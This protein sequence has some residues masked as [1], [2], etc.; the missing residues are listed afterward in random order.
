MSY[1]LF[2]QRKMPSRRVIVDKV[3]AKK[4]FEMKLIEYDDMLE[5]LEPYGPDEPFHIRV[6]PG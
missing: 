1:T 2:V 3:S 6:L 4:R 5:A